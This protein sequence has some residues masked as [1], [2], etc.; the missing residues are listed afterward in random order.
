MGKEQNLCFGDLILDE[1]CLF[2]SRNGKTIQFTR[3]ERAVLLVLT[4]NPHRL[5]PR[6]RLLDEIDPSESDRSDRYIDFLINRLRTKLGDNKRSPKYIATQY[7]E[8]YVWIAAPSSAVP[9][10]GFLIIGAAFGPQ[11]H[12]FSRQASSLLGRLRDTIAASVGVGHKVVVV[13]ENPVTTDKLHYFLQV[14]FHAG[15]GRLECAATL[16]EMPSKRIVKAF[17]LHLDETD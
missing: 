14:S 8:G 17:R 15:N 12:A 4:R 16:R 3:N 11:G 13:A 1:T 6:S 7:G 5:L 9:I 10:D 2:A